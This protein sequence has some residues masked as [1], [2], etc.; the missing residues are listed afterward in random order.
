MLL[1]ASLVIA[2]LGP[3][4]AEAS[5]T[6]GGTTTSTVTTLA[7]SVC[8][9]STA[10]AIG[11]A[12]VALSSDGVGGF[13]VAD[14]TYSAV[15]HVDATGAIHVVAGNGAYGYLGD[16]GP[17]TAAELYSPMGLAAAADGTLYIADRTNQRIRRVDGQ[18]GTITTLAGTGVP[19]F[20][21]ASGTSAAFNYPAGLALDALNHL[22]VAD[23]KNNR[24]RRIDLL[25]GAVSTVAGTGYAAYSGDGGPA[26]SATLSFPTGVAIDLDGSLLIA[27]SNN[28][29]VRRVDA[30]GV[31]TTIAG[32]VTGYAG[33][34]GAATAAR[35]NHPQSIAVAAD[36]V[37]VA[38][39]GNNRIRAVDRAGTITT[40]AG[41]GAAAFSGDHGAA[42]AAALNFPMGVATSP[43]GT[44]LI[45][46]AGNVR[47]RAVGLDGTITTVAGN[48]THG[49]SGDGG[50]ANGAELNE[51]IGVATAAD[52]SVVV[53]DSLNHVV[54]RIDAGGTIH[55][56]AGTPGVAGGDGDGGPALSA[57]LQFPTGV[58]VDRKGVIYVADNGN[59]R[60]RKIT[61]DGRITTIAGTGVAGYSGDGG[62]ATKATLHAPASVAVGGDGSIFVADSTNNSVRQVRTNGT[63]V[64]FAGSG[65]AGF[66]GDGG[67]ASKAMLRTPNG[68]AVDSQGT[69]FIADTDNQRIRAVDLKSLRIRTVAG[70]GAVGFSGNGTL[71]SLALFNFP[72][73]LV[74]DGRGNVYVA[75]KG[76]CVIRKI[77]NA[78]TSSPTVSTVVGW[79]PVRSVSPVCG[80]AGEGTP[81]LTNG[82]MLDS[83]TGVAYD[84]SGALVFADSLS[85]RV[86]RVTAI[87]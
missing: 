74:A 22:Y 10:T 6:L 52:G 50:P 43:V 21:D 31:I 8:S 36:A 70:T 32:T 25:T 13:F 18:T 69:V 47:V 86:R 17:A 20:A 27:D 12:P 64:T 16:G 33:D 44:V 82:T 85:N 34:G 14:S 58:A 73:G 81:P 39:S 68:V 30:A 15:C 77:G 53:A 66:G 11:F 41:T 65:L 87:A 55:I 23:T 28:A 63:I 7:G 59:N 51:P 72:T 56:V 35:L 5:V 75:D 71:G 60:V 40:V 67:P 3:G 78:T 49:Y 61:V 46:D 19:G 24:V 48:G 9:P 45:A 2:V 38:D 80:F 57:H 62:P 84:G 4:D 37:F 79:P 83:P 76:N 54:R 1:T 26:L 42:N 29:R